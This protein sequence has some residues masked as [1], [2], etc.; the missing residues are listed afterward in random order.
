MFAARLGSAPVSFGSSVSGTAAALEAAG[1]APRDRLLALIEADFDV[2]ACGP[3]VLPIWFAFWGEL[4]FTETYAEVAEAFDAGRRVAVSRVWAEL[5]PE[6]TADEAEKMA[7]WMDTLTDGYW[8]RL[9]LAPDSFD[10]STARDATR[11]CLTRLLPE[12][13]G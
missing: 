11:E 6:A 3:D 9:H 13:R 1:P 8:Q 12:L 5:M 10:R 2:R 7:E 4:R